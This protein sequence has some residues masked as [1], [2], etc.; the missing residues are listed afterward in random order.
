VISGTISIRR[1]LSVGVVLWC[2]CVVAPPVS[3]AVVVRGSGTGWSP[4]TITIRRGASISWRAGVGSHTV[5][6]YGRNWSYFRRVAQG[7][8]TRPRRFTRSGTYR[9]YCTYHGF[10]VGSTCYGMCGTIVVR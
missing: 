5:Q 4:R 3:A 10:V 1:V 9:F 8:S 2:I 7:S 6:S